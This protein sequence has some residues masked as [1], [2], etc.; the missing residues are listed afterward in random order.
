MHPFIFQVVR[1]NSG[2]R[3]NST[4][5]FHFY[6][7]YGKHLVKSEVNISTFIP[8][9]LVWINRLHE[10]SC[11]KDIILLSKVLMD[12]AGHSLRTIFGLNFI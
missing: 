12:K 9:C 4:K 2:E 10:N 5:S 8:V 6:E 1:Q 11:N 7:Y 3:N